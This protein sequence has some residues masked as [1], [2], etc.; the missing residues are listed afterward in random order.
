MIERVPGLLARRRDGLHAALADPRRYERQIDRLQQRHLFDGGMRRLREGDVSLGTVVMHRDHVARLLARAVSSGEYRVGAATLRSI[1]VDGKPRTI[2]ELPLFDRIVHGVVADVLSEAVEPIVEASVYSYRPGVSWWDGVAAFSAYI[3]AHR[4]ERPDPRTRGLYVLRRDIDT[5]TDSIPLGPSSAIWSQLEGALAGRGWEGSGSA[6]DRALIRA[7]VRP[8]VRSAAGQVEQRDRGVA[9]GMPISCL[10]FNL[11]LADVDREMG[12]VTGAFWARYSD[13]IV[14]AHPD[15]DV[16]RQADALL[17]RRVGELGLQFNRHKSQDLYVT[18]AGRESAE[19]PEARGASAVAFL[20]MRV[21]ADGTVAL[22][23]RK[24]R[25]FLREA[26]RRAANAARA[27]QGLPP[28]TR[29][30]AIVAALRR[31]IDADDADLQGAAAPLLARAVTDR[32]QLDALDHEL[33]GMVAAAVAGRPAPQA[34]RSVPYRRIRQ[35]WGLPSLRMTR[36][37]VPARRAS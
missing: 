3:R 18:A 25:D 30:R 11:F 2:F 21:L 7:V 10:C 29:G 32:H 27:S 13:D 8:E 12:A 17:T 34:F 24:V 23:H 20:G 9:T 33:A 31:L 4:R 14:F 19:W 26:R 5:Y 16:T 35:D 28:E 1:R 37:R 15:P 22:G 36:D 6:A